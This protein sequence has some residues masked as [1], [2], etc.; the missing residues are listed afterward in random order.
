MI[1]HNQKKREPRVA[2]S[3]EQVAQLKKIKQFKEIVKVSNFKKTKSY[4]YLNIIC[5]LSFIIYV[6]L[7]LCY[8]GPCNYSVY[9]I[10]KIDVN[11]SGKVNSNQQPLI[12]T[13]KIT[14]T[15]NKLTTIVVDDF[16]DIPEVGSKFNIGKD[17]IFGK[18]IKANVQ[19]YN[20]S[21][22]VQRFS[23]V[24]F[25]SCFLSVFCIILF[26]Y[27]LNHQSHSLTALSII[28]SVAVLSFCFI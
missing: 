1:N 15:Q 6:E 10:K 21:F 13:L 12:S 2:L 14:D 23:P 5:V 7:I 28:N 19:G 16:I 17:Y 25:L 4:K 24:L 9:E 22:R 18:Q 20:S 27:N 26:A 3:P 8:I 11:Y